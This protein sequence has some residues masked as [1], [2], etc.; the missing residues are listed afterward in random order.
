M[1]YVRCCQ[2]QNNTHTRTSFPTQLTTLE[3]M[4]ERELGAMREAAEAAKGAL[5]QERATWQ[6][7]R[8]ELMQRAAF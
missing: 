5:E 6:Q 4:F 7:E 1:L 3:G 2:K 8:A